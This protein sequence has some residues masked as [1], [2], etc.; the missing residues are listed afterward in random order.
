MSTLNPGD[1]VTWS[2]GGRVREGALLLLFHKRVCDAGGRTGCWCSKKR[3]Y[4][5]LWA[6][7]RFQG[8]TGCW[9]IARI[10]ASRLKLK[11]ELS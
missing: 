11:G 9:H 1:Q 8:E 4:D 10:R 2:R 3:F 7:V 6:N 5:T